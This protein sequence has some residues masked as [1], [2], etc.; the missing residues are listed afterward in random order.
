M[1]QNIVKYVNFED[2]QYIV[3]NNFNN[4]III[5]TLPSTEQNVLIK[6]TI[7]IDNEISI[8]NNN[9]NKLTLK[10]II[11]GKNDLDKKVEEKYN[12]LSSLGFTNIFIYRGGLFEWL[13]LQDIYGKDMFP[14][15]KHE[16][17]ILKYKSKR[18]FNN[19]LLS[20]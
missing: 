20:N 5:N 18:L 7:S 19:N 6:N 16:L 9:L 1:G 12:Q 17:D 10:I 13:L 2:V 8:I 14:T 15:T 3:S 11:Y 4:Y